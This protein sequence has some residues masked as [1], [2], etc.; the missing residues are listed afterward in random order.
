MISAN[1]IL[2]ILNESHQYSVILV[3]LKDAT[4][5]G[6]SHSLEGRLNCFI[7]EGTLGASERARLVKEMS[8][9]Y[10]P[11]P[12]SHLPVEQFLSSIEGKK[13]KHIWLET[14]GTERK[15]LAFVSIAELKAHL[16]T[17]SKR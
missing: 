15:E 6:I 3:E 17:H 2:Q 9:G 16:R 11:K 1:D 7:L 14:G 5:V 4:T 13:A 12:L 10:S 8:S